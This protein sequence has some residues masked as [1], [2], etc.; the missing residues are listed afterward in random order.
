MGPVVDGVDRYRRGQWAEPPSHGKRVMIANP[1]GDCTKGDGAENDLRNPSW[2]GTER[3]SGWRAGGVVAASSDLHN[4]VEDWHCPRPKGLTCLRI[5]WQLGFFITPLFREVMK[6]TS[7]CSSYLFRKSLICTHI[8]TLI[9]YIHFELWM[10]K[11]KML[12]PT[13]WNHW[14]I[15]IL[16]V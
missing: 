9:W 3:L 4:A 5:S 15:A 11:L 10:D 1:T 7:K 12:T 16:Q 6:L 2:A 14:F 13:S 8:T